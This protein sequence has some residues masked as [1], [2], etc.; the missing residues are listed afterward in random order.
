MAHEIRRV[1]YFHTTVE[2][3]PGVAL[4]FLSALNDLGINLVAFTAI[5]VGLLQTQLTIFP[6]DSLQLQEEGRKAGFALDGPHPALLVQ[7]DDV[8]GAV[9]QIHEALYEAGVNV[10]ASSGV[11]GGAG[12]YG[13]IIH[14]RPE[15]FNAAAAAVGL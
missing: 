3:R 2:D 9:V 1:D 14:V 11:A 12:S 6:V 8:P 13:Y 5:P 10:Y 4:Q 7:G 15:D